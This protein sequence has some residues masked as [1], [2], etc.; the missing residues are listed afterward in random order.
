LA[1][2]KATYV[3]EEGDTCVLNAGTFSDFLL[4]LQSKCAPKTI[5]NL[6]ST[7]CKDVQV[8]DCRRK[9]EHLAGCVS[10][11][12]VAS[13]NGAYD[14]DGDQDNDE[15]LQHEG[16]IEEGFEI[17]EASTQC[18]TKRTLLRTPDGDYKTASALQVGDTV[19]GSNGDSVEV[20]YKKE[21]PKKL[22]KFVTIIT[23]TA[24]LIVTT[25]H[26]VVVPSSAGK[27]KPAGSLELDDVVFCGSKLQ[28][29]T[30]IMKFEQRSD[31]IELRFT[32]DEAVEALM[33]NPCGI[34]TKGDREH[35]EFALHSFFN[36]AVVAR[37]FGPLGPSSLEE[38]V[39]RFD[40]R[41]A[42]SCER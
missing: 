26:R 42:R 29:I 24:D 7:S 32:P 31:L 35:S 9:C 15:V 28:R 1:S 39:A 40:R 19:L 20:A 12:A 27:E 14:V 41:R 30:K 38:N 23:A 22:R 34:L 10:S 3:D 21:H 2:L 6:E 17:L 13:D 8:S 33:V 4:T 5:V 25:D 16:N 36:S 18:F 37:N 11:E